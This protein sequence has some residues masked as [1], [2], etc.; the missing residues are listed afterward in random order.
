MY[1]CI[2]GFSTWGEVICARPVKFRRPYVPNMGSQTAPGTATW[3]PC[4]STWALQT[5]L[6]SQD[7]SKRPPGSIFEQFW[8]PP[9]GPAGPK[10]L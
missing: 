3:A 9:G 4:T 1:C 6:R 5:D 7:T 10:T 2:D 8:T